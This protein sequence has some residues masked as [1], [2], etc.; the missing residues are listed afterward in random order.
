[1][2]GRMRAPPITLTNYSHLMP[3]LLF[4]QAAVLWISVQCACGAVSSLSLQRQFD[5]LDMIFSRLPVM[6]EVRM[7]EVAPMNRLFSELLA[8]HP[9]IAAAVR[10]SSKG[11]VVNAAGQDSA[12]FGVGSDVSD[13]AWFGVPKKTSAAWYGKLTKDNMRSSVV[14][15]RPVIVASALGRTRFG[16]IVAFKID[17]TQCFKRFASQMQGAFAIL[18]NGKPYYYLAWDDAVPFSESQI[19]LPGD[20]RFAVRVPKKAAAAKVDSSVGAVPAVRRDTVGPAGAGPKEQAAAGTGKAGTAGE[21]PG[22]SEQPSGTFLLPKLINAAVVIAV[23]FCF[24]LALAMVRKRKK[25][26]RTGQPVPDLEA[27]LFEETPSPESSTPL[28]GDEKKKILEKG[29]QR[30]RE[31]FASQIQE[32]VLEELTAELRQRVKNEQTATIYKTIRA[33]L[34]DELKQQVVRDEKEELA[35]EARQAVTQD[36]R[37]SVE[38]EVRETVRQTVEGEIQREIR[39]QVTQQEREKIYARELE[40]LSSEIRQQIIEKEMQPLITA[41]REKLSQ[42]IRKKIGESYRDII[43]EQV[44]EELRSDIAQALRRQEYSRLLDEEKERLRQEAHRKVA[45]EESP[46][47]AAQVRDQLIEEIRAKLAECEGEVIRQQ[48]RKELTDSI[49]GEITDRETEQI[50][51]QEREA[52]RQELLASVSHRERAR[53]QEE[54]LSALTEEERRRV[55][56]ENREE[57]IA[58]EKNRLIA[59]ES[60]AL[61]QQLRQQIIKEELQNVTNEVKAQ[62]YSETVQAIKDN[63]EAHYKTAVTEKIAEVKKT[64]QKKSKSDIRGSLKVEYQACLDHIEQLSRFLTNIEALQSLT[65]TVTLLSEE[66]KKYKYFNLNTAQT[67]S[68]IDY[69]KRTANRFNIYFDKVD[70]SVRELMLKVGSIMNKLDNQD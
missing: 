53:I 5:T 26:A 7:K 2:R 33:E 50:K 16:G 29:R 55:R 12:A 42:E 11:V 27:A 13:S 23:V 43:E 62:I 41:H 51:R 59:E 45:E 66:K 60:E 18:L 19:L 32:K 54:I 69:L 46:A 24:V 4:I 44:R 9:E 14:W 64:L 3:R 8:Q 39:E 15:S 65:Q 28:S 38:Q 61:R 22:P 20:I 49:R 57:I 34:V 10:T 30:A 25:R 17:V 56:E 6:P 47:I 37:R 68:L 21:P 31:L 52:L 36:L 48:L 70:E 1:M 40:S 58:E 67:E 63:L 35:N